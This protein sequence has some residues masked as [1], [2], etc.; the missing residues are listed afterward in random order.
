MNTEEVSRIPDDTMVY[1]WSNQHK[2]YRN[3][4]G[5]VGY[6]ESREYAGEYDLSDAIE[7]CQLTNAMLPLDS[8]LIETVV[9]IPLG[10]E[11]GADRRAARKAE[12]WGPIPVALAIAF[13]GSLGVGLIAA[14][15]RADDSETFQSSPANDAIELERKSV[16]R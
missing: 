13:W 3:W 9:P 8:P 11:T 16:L 15:E 5:N 4:P 1:I 2:A 10:D 6:L 12:E 7:I 14:C